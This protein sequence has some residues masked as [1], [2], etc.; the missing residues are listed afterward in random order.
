MKWI[1]AITLGAWFL[2]APA[3]SS[4][5]MVDFYDVATG[6]DGVTSNGYAGS[7]RNSFRALVTSCC[8]PTLPLFAGGLGLLGWMARRRRSQ[9]AHG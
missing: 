7:N 5:T 9:A 6:T 1:V 4:P 3:T 8:P 2:S